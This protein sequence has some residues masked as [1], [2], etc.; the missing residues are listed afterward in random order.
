MWRGFAIKKGTPEEACKWWEDLNK[1]VA[2]DPEWRNFLVRDGIFVV[3]WGRDKFNKQVK[4]DL[5]AA[6]RFI[7]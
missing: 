2:K 6:Q 3:D 5:A 1:K 7:K 4:E